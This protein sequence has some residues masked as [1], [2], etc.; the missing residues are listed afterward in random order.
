V[1]LPRRWLARLQVMEY[2]RAFL[3]GR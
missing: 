2:L 1:R 3:A